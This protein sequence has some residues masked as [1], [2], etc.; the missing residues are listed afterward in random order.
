M[1]LSNQRSDQVWGGNERNRLV[2]EGGE[3]D[4]NR[5]EDDEAQNGDHG[6]RAGNRP[7]R[8][9]KWTAPFNAA[10]I[11]RAAALRLATG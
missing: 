9:G 2:V 7:T 6:E 3:R 8:A 5:R 10:R 11:F 1:A 4:D